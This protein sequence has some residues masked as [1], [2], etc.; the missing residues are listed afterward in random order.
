M[1]RRLKKEKKSNLVGSN[2]NTNSTFDIY[3]KGAFIGGVIGGVS[4]LVLGRKI[5]LGIFIGS[6]LG[7]FINY[8]INKQ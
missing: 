5:L 8:E 1:K 2:K 4:G 7:G 3:K 6:L